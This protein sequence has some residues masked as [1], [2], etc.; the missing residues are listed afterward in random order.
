MSLEMLKVRWN[1]LRGLYRCPSLAMEEV[2]VSEI[3][4]WRAAK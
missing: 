1:D 2:P 4:P 3:D